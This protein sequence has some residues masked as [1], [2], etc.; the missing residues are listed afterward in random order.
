M[1]GD[2]G[3]G[4]GGSGRRPGGA[5]SALTRSWAAGALVHLGAGFLM[6]RSLLELLGTEARLE[7]FGWRMALLHIPTLTVTLLTVLAAA[8]MLP[9]EHRESRAL[10]LLATLA[11]PLAGL[12]Y[13]F[14]V[15]WEAVG[16]EGSLMPVASLATGAAAG[17]AVDRL[18]EERATRPPPPPRYSYNWRDSGATTTEYLGAV[19]LAVALIGALAIAGRR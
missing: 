5:F 1:N 13:G 18:L 15:P 6:S 9:D 3:W 4:D 11:V 16:I 12:A 19:I 7:A 14:A 2:G 17:V 10:Y 8:R